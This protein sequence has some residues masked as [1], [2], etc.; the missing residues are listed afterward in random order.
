MTSP[1]KREANRRNA[2]NST[3]PKTRLGRK[4]A[5]FN[6]LKHGLT[7]KTVLLPFE[8]G[9]AYERAAELIYEQYRPVGA[10]EECLTELVIADRWR[11]AR[12]SR[13]EDEFVVETFH[14]L[15]NGRESKGESR[16][17]DTAQI[18]LRKIFG[19]KFSSP[20]IDASSSPPYVANAGAPERNN[21]V[22][23]TAINDAPDS[24]ALRTIQACLDDQSALLN[25][26][27]PPSTA[28]PMDE[29]ARQRRS[30]T[31]ELLRNIAALEVIQSRRKSIA[32]RCVRTEP[33]AANSNIPRI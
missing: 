29:V 11:L 14:N 28:A 3:G 17:C 22:G 5:N 2:A 27:V 21:S 12:F 24:G 26:Y 20:E 16:D 10:I 4:R 32:T 31:R 6:A 13:V 9:Q 8:D 1:K 7:A 18:Q 33:G 25:A 19:D 23:G 15:F 30:A